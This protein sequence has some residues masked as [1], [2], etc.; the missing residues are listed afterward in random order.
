MAEIK[1]AALPVMAAAAPD[2]IR[3]MKKIISMRSVT[4]RP[5]K[6][7]GPAGNSNCRLPAISGESWQRTERKWGREGPLYIR[8][9]SV[10]T[11]TLS[12][13]SSSGRVWPIPAMSYRIS[14]I[15]AL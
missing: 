7:F 15:Q 4:T 3:K 6:W 10:W 1:G 12:R 11:A 13:L 5:N 8:T 9:T 14:P 2:A